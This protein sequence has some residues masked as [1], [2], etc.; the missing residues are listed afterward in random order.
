M[1]RQTSP[2]NA[3]IQNCRRTGHLCRTISPK[4]RRNSKIAVER[5][6]GEVLLY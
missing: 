3:K 6:L 2:K 4:R 1:A 5:S